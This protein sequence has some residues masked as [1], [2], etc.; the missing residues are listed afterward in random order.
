MKKKFVQSN[1]QS[2]TTSVNDAWSVDEDDDDA[3]ARR[4]I[5]E[6]GA[7]LGIDAGPSDRGT[8]ALLWWMTQGALVITASFNILTGFQKTLEKNVI[9]LVLVLRLDVISSYRIMLAQH[10]LWNLSPMLLLVS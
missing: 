8:I 2:G 5:S 7:R 3:A 10:I 4:I 1:N 9:A 6:K